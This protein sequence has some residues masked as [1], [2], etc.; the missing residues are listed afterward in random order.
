MKTRRSGRLA[1]RFPRAVH[2][3]GQFVFL[4]LH[5]Y[6]K[7]NTFHRTDCDNM[8]FAS[9]FPNDYPI[10]RIPLHL[11]GG[12]SFS[13]F[14]A[15]ALPNGNPAAAQDHVAYQHI[16]RF[17]SS[18]CYHIAWYMHAPGSASIKQRHQDETSINSKDGHIQQARIL[19]SRHA[20]QRA[21]TVQLGFLQ[22][23]DL[24]GA[25]TPSKGSRR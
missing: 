3:P 10:L 25:K 23:P 21:T 9:V 19:P 6:H 20:L 16:N 17:D 7:K 24:S 18:T 5:F 12:V 15:T 11:S 22:R 13:A 14:H 1:P 8:P 4:C 2:D